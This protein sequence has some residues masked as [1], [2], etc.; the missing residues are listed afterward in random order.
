MV[1]SDFLLLYD[2]V[3]EGYIF[4]GIYSFLLGF[5]LVGISLV[6]VISYEPLCFY[7]IHYNVSFIHLFTH[8]FMYLFCLF[9]PPLFF[10]VNLLKN[11]SYIFIF[12]KSQLSVLLIF[13]IVFFICFSFH[14]VTLGCVCSSFSSFLRLKL[15]C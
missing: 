1:Y 15:D 4:L 10:L 9:E 14:L 12:S 3:L 8:L 2:S 13:S 7:G 6:I 5:Q 11:L